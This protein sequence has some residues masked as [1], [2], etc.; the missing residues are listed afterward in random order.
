MIVAAFAA[1]MLGASAE[2]ADSESQPV[3][4]SA[5]AASASSAAAESSHNDSPQGHSD[6]FA[7]VLLVF[8]VVIVAAMLGRRIAEKLGQ[9]PVL[10]ELMIGV[11]LGYVATTLIDA[12]ILTLLTHFNS[13]EHLFAEVWSRGLAPEQAALH[14]FSASELA[15]GG[16]GQRIMGLLQGPHGEV[17]L[18]TG[19]TISMFSK[20]GVVLLLFM[21]GLEST[22]PDMLRVGVRATIVAMVGMAAPIVLGLAATL[23]LLPNATIPAHAFIITTLC[24][25]S[26]GVTAR[27]FR[28]LNIVQSP[29]ARVILGAAVIDD[30]LGLIALAIVIGVAATGTIDIGQVGGILAMATVFLALLILVGEKLARLK[31]RL[32]HWIDPRDYPLLFPLALACVLAWVADRI[33]LATI[34]GAFAAGLILR[35]EMFNLGGRT[36]THLHERFASLE[37][38]FAPIF[39]VLVGIQ[40]DLVALAEPRTLLV[41]GLLTVAAVAGKL[42]CGLAAGRGADALTIGM[43]MVPRG[44]VGLI[45]AQVGRSMGVLS[46]AQFSALVLV[47][48]ATTLLTP[49]GLKW[50][51]ARAR[52]RALPTQL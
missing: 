51:V 2:R 8:G 43:G 49:L 9:P 20:L 36:N 40:V 11:G 25:T 6:P 19:M 45:F 21:V 16:I 46:D 27:V 35:D 30:V 41:G 7:S 13:V 17:L 22:V 26:V 50:T 28:D 39:F 44:E 1:L 32:F 4:H 37:K 10:G 33:Q 18:M 31:A 29:E 12:P 34:V 23:T 3:T 38:V 42:A 52:R 48:A 47:V 14:V 15:A 5:P 24:A